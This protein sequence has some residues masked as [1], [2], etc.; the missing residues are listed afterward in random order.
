MHGLER[1]EGLGLIAGGVAHDF[2]N[3]LVGVLG[4]A[5]LLAGSDDLSA[6]DATSVEAILDAGQRAAQ[7]CR[8]LLSYA[9][10][11]P[12]E[13]ES[14]DLTALVIEML[15]VLRTA[16]RPRGSRSTSNST[17]AR[18]GPSATLHRSSKRCSTS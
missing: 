11:K 8:S 7:L 13:H 1:L 17:R 5:E 4:N 6:D 14:F 18:P 9:G 15:P 3:L 2:N 16:A 12:V 10:T